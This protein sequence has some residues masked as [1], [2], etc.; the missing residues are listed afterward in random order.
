MDAKSK[1]LTISARRWFDRKAGNTYH[2]VKIYEGSELIA[3]VPFAYG[4]DDAYK[5]TAFYELVKLGQYSGEENP[6]GSPKE[7]CKFA[8]SP[9]IGDG[10]LFI[11]TDVTR[12]RDL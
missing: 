4:Y 9:P 5:L 11:V 1:S 6:N 10:H 2:S 12:K 7:Y 8:F 3:Q